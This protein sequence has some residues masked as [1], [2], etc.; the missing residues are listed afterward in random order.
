[1]IY[2]R[3]RVEMHYNITTRKQ[4]LTIAREAWKLEPFLPN[5]AAYM[6]YKT[7]GLVV[8]RCVYQAVDIVASSHG[9]Y[10]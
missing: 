8:V 1:M 6:S 5:M 4:K 9:N 10:M 7:L 3:N 2:K